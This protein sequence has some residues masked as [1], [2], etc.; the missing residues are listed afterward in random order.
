MASAIYHCCD[1]LYQ[2]M[3]LGCAR[4]RRN[5]RAEGEEDGS[6]QR[7]PLYS[8][9]AAMSM[10]GLH[11]R[12]CSF[13]SVGRREGRQREEGVISQLQRCLDVC[14]WRWRKSRLKRSHR[15]FTRTNHLSRWVEGVPTV[16]Y[17]VRTAN[18]SRHTSY[19]YPHR[20]TPPSCTPRLLSIALLSY[21][22]QSSGFAQRP[23]PRVQR[24]QQK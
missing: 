21:Y 17:K 2:T 8:I 5:G 10:D 11:P 9:P 20:Q 14:W 19:T 24:S 23:K 3:L 13:I 1:M 22:I 15:P 4:V 16:P 12:G 6:S 18:R 7:H